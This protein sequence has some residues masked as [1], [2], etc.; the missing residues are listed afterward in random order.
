MLKEGGEEMGASGS[1][2]S[3]MG[4]PL[5]LFVAVAVAILVVLA[6]LF[7]LISVR[8]KGR[9]CLEMVADRFRGEDV[10]CQDNSASFFGKKSKKFKQVR[11]NGVLILTRRELFFR[12]LMPESEISIPLQ[13]VQ[14]VETPLSFL[15]KSIF[16]PLLKVDYRTETGEADSIAW[17]VK[18]LKCFREGIENQR[19]KFG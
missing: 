6:L 12:R 7:L 14:G 15:G 11:G 2:V 8:R 1:G 16:R 13:N 10:I 9:E 5:W 4:H 19:T 3:W 18:N 17:Y